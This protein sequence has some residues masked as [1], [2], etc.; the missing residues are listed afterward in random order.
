[1]AEG[2]DSV[3]FI[4]KKPFMNYVTGVVMQFNSGI[5]KVTVKARGKYISRAVDVAEV[6]RNRFVTDT[7]LNDIKIASEEFQGD[8]GKKIR[9]STIEIVLEKE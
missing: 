6:V 8:D 1:M 3:V 5:K 9:I 4:G 2:S 7:K